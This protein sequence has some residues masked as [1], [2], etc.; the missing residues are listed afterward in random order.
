MCV[1]VSYIGRVADNYDVFILTLSLSRRVPVEQICTKI[2]Q[3]V[4]FQIRT[5]SPF[6]ITFPSLHN[7]DTAVKTGSINNVR[8][9]LLFKTILSP[10]NYRG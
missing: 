10:Y 2:Y 9:N 6:I 7:L 5:Y 8:I 3:T 1:S 4:S